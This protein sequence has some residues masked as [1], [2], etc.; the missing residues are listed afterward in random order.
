M[1]IRYL[2]FEEVVHLH[3]LLCF[4]YGGPSEILDRGMV[5]SAIAQPGMA[6]FGAEPYSTLWLKAAAYCYYLCLNH[7]F[8]DGNKRTGVAAAFH[9]LR[10]NGIRPSCSSELLYDAVLRVMEKRCTVEEL[11]TVLQG[12]Q[13]D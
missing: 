1:A 8:R 11:A 9:F 10:K 4:F 6:V 7:G 3:D 2:T 5:E 12:E 13:A